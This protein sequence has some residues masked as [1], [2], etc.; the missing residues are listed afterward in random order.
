MKLR[1]KIL[2]ALWVLLPLV[3]VGYFLE[4]R[5]GKPSPE[6]YQEIAADRVRE[7]SASN[8]LQNGDLIFHTSRS[9]QSQ[10][11]QL[12]TKSKYSHCGIVYREGE[13]YFV[14]EAVQPVS[15]TP[16]A[17]WIARGEG[18]HFVVK[19]LKN[20]HEVLSPS[21]LAKMKQ[22][23][24]K[25]AGKD[26]DLTFEWSDD[27]IYCSELIWKVYQRATGL[28][29][30]KLEKL[31]DFDLTA[32]PVQAKMRER[33]GHNIPLEEKVISPA[34]MFASDLLVTVLEK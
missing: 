19:R 25:L 4:K 14:Y 2:L 5:Y 3:A 18:G 31:K 9:A 6:E 7:L 28:E 32:K 23:G 10:A 30:G 12:A 34:S 24:E 33:Y 29:I 27:K 8:E 15:T 11:I 21:A 22:E 17:R 26:Y 1:S 13:N 20:A 16:L